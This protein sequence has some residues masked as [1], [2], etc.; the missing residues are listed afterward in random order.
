MGS[1]LVHGGWGPTL[2]HPRHISPW[3]LCLRYTRVE[4][5]G[6]RL[7][8]TPFNLLA[9]STGRRPAATTCRGAGG[10]RSSE[11]R[12]GQ[13]GS[14]LVKTHLLCRGGEQI[15]RVHGALIADTFEVWRLSFIPATIVVVPFTSGLKVRP[16]WT[17]AAW[18]PWQRF[19]GSYVY[20]E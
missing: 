3:T 17:K 2:T 7:P 6:H 12:P 14:S 5:G 15:I 13:P 1:E 16:S 4:S 9:P 19:T 8:R 18:A 11:V 10:S 20:Q